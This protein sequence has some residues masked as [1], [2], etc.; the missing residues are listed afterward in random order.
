VGEIG[1]RTGMTCQCV[2]KDDLNMDSQVIRR[3]GWLTLWL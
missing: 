2:W 3:V 1:W